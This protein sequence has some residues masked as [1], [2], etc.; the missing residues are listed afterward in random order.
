[1]IPSWSKVSAIFHRRPSPPCYPNFCLSTGRPARS[2]GIPRA[3]GQVLIAA[4]QQDTRETK[5][6]PK[7][8]EPGQR[9][10]TR[11]AG[12]CEAEAVATTKA[13]PKSIGRLSNCLCASMRAYLSADIG[14]RAIAKWTSATARF[15]PRAA[16]ICQI[17][18]PSCASGS[19]GNFG[20]DRKLPPRLMLSRR[21]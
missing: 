6:L 11:A 14:S 12:Q 17:C 16:G 8:R 19:P 3:Q 1:M 5:M 15:K 10:Q 9:L 13:H 2:W 21:L 7:W 18:F 4:Q 20:P